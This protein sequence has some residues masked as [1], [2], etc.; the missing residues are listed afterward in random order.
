[1]INGRNDSLLPLDSSQKPMYQ[2]LGTPE[3]HKH[4]IVV[5]EGTH[6]VPQDKLE[7]E[8][9]HFLDRYSGKPFV[10]T[11]KSTMSDASE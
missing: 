2:L 5:D 11:L 9:I 7:K 3:E 6:T 10:N 4:H 1:M 8:T